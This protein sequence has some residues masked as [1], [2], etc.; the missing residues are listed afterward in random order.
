ML[1]TV[2]QHLLSDAQ[3]VPKQ[4]SATPGQLT[5]VYILGMTFYGMECPFS[6]LGQLF[7]AVLPCQ[8]LCTSSL[9]KR[10]KSPEKPLIRVNTT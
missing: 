3:P 5:A 8:F 2:A 6:Q 9:A 7:L 1:T 4:Y 10:G